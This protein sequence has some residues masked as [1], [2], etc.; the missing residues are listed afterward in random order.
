MSTLTAEELAEFEEQIKLQEQAKVVEKVKKETKTRVDEDGTV[1]EWDDN[2]KAW[3][4]KIDDDFIANY[5]MNFG[6]SDQSNVIQQ[7]QAF[8][9]ET[10]KLKAE[11]GEDDPVVKKRIESYETAL[12]QYFSS[13]SY[14][15]WYAQYQA[16]QQD[17][18]PAPKKKAAKR[19]ILDDEDPEEALLRA[20]HEQKEGLPLPEQP[21]AQK[22]QEKKEIVQKKKQAGPAWYDVSTHLSSIRLIKIEFAK[23]FDNFL[24]V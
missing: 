18:V 3:F 13:D 16:S 2:K 14:R 22:E 12:Q 7:W 4:P 1:M 6:V 19:T 10:Q 23:F 21:Q 11:K 9:E 20:E 15:Q 24:L 5:N 17:P 8:L